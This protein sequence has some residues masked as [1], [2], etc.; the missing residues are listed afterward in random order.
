MWKGIGSGGD[1]EVSKR[2]M[3][4][5]AKG[6]ADLHDDVPERGLRAFK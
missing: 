5:L 3:K 4:R 6:R 2:L 1:R